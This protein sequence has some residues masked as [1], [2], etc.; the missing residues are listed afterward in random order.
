MASAIWLLRKALRKKSPGEGRS[1]P[2]RPQARPQLVSP[3]EAL[4]EA[5]HCADPAFDLGQPVQPKGHAE[6]VTFRD[7]RRSQSVRGNTA[8]WTPLASARP[9]FRRS[10]S[11][12]YRAIECAGLSVM[13]KMFICSVSDD[14][15]LRTQR[16]AASA[17]NELEVREAMLRYLGKDFVISR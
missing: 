2:P 6:P 9:F 4:G 15:G 3:R 17:A 13:Y 8:N 11:F 5:A 12:A 14:K 1:H 7:N 10:V 16:Y